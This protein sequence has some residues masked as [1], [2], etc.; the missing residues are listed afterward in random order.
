MRDKIA[1]LKKRFDEILIIDNKI[2]VFDNGLIILLEPR[3][4]KVD[5]VF[6]SD[7]TVSGDMNGLFEKTKED[8]PNDQFINS[9]K[10]D[11]IH[12]TILVSA[13]IDDNKDWSSLVT[14]FIESILSFMNHVL[15][16]KRNEH[17][18]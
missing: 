14:S 16:K 11:S 17:C 6:V 7:Q 4:G 5:M 13:T 9:L 12:N 10:F 2:Y 15:S 8:F 1:G 18:N 3:N